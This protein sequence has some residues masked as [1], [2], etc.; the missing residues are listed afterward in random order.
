LS[1]HYTFCRICEASCG[2]QVEVQDNRVTRIRPDSDHP[3]TKGYA[4][5]K[6]IRFDEVQHAPDRVL[7]PLKRSGEELTPT[8]WDAAIEEIGR[9][10]RAIIDEHG[11]QSVGFY[12]G[13]P[14]GFSTTIPI[15]LNGLASAIRTKKVFSVGSLDC[16]NKFRVSDEMYGS[17]FT[18]TFPDIKNT[19]F[20]MMIGANPAVS[21]TSVMQLP[22]PITELQA[23]EERG[24]KVVFLNPRRIETAKAVGE[25]HFIRPGTD[26]F[27]LLSFLRELLE[28][29]AV[30]QD[31]VGRHMSGLEDVAAMV[32]PWTPEKTEKVTQ[33]P[34]QTLRALARQY[35]DAEGASLF[36]STGVNQGGFGTLAFW[37]LEVI[38]AVSG[39]LDREGGSV[40]SKGAI[41]LPRLG[42]RGGMFRR[43]R[44]SRFGNLP[45]VAD[46]LPT[47][48]LADEIL[49]PG[50]GQQI[51]ALFV[52]AGNP[53]LSAPNPRGRLTKAFKEL[54]LLVS[55]DLFRSET[56]ELA[57]FVL[58]GPTFL[59]RPDLQ[60]A[61]QL[62]SGTQPARYLQYT[63]PVLKMPDTVRD[64]WWV[65]SEIARAAGLPFFGNRFAEKLF[66][67]NRRAD[68]RPAVREW[69]SLNHKRLVGLFTLLGS[70]MTPHRLAKRHPHGRML[71]P[72]RPGWFLKRGLLTRNGRVELAPID[73]L[74]GAEVELETGYQQELR[75]KTTLKLI[76]KREKRGHNSWMHNTP[77]L[78]GKAHTTNR[79]YMHPDDA[80]EAGLRQGDLA[81]IG[82]E[83]GSVQAPVHIS[84]DIMRYVVALPH[85][86]GHQDSGLAYAS[87]HRAGVNVNA[88]AG[89]G[90]RHTERLSG[91]AQLTA[92]PVRV[93]P[94]G[95][96]ERSEE[97]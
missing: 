78:G 81:E 90:A 97:Q 29:G 3:V 59:E 8:T 83:Q 17:P 35:A 89:D 5:V 10:L 51:K 20:L 58:P 45:M 56:A 74:D 38:N 65:F 32:Q 39:N 12:I 71:K 37:V 21:H 33:V 53:I 54:D 87:A 79:L 57:D 93:K 40:V 25:H 4:C 82:T 31:K 44:K 69:L 26:V 30:D 73:F 27:F 94:V 86:W 70:G 63:D 50:E 34:A 72:N 43:G 46:N 13:N 52:V 66:D 96:P 92:F 67:L 62:M 9:R 18:L 6:G 47:T 1:T 24:G 91:M 64:E 7:Q 22:H 55:M 48:T 75:S 36:C 85:G 61:F 19:K 49:T 60:M 23:I 80:S 88:L 84:D 41:D 76:S 14:C 2:L 11:P 16:A 77:A 15:F 42:K 28:M 68:K 95:A